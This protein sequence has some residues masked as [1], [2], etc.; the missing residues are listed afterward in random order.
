MVIEVLPGTGVI[1]VKALAEWLHTDPNSLQQS[2]SNNG[3][4][5]LKLSSRFDKK[6]VRLEDL[7][8]KAVV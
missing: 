7:R 4:P 5:V 8:K 3:I 2:L 1:T 6:L